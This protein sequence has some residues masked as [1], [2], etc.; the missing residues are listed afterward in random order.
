MKKE[1]GGWKIVGPVPERNR[2]WDMVSLESS[3]DSEIFPLLA[4]SHDLSKE[5]TSTP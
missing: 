2:E 5:V 3:L 4:R 1:P